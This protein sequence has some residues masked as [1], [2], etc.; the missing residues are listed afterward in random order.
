MPS[1][2]EK[3]LKHYR[4]VAELI[5]AAKPLER[6]QLNTGAKMVLAEIKRHLPDADNETI[7][8]FMAS[9]GYMAAGLAQMNIRE[10]A[11]TL[12][13]VFDHHMLAVCSMLEL[14]NLDDGD[15]AGPSVEEIVEKR[16]AREAE[17]RE[18]ASQASS[19]DMPGQYL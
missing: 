3:E 19:D 6:T 4:G 16:N 18:A 9:I 12:E 8:S 15:E 5:Y 2:S 17:W 11:D 1:A 10:L 7:R 13:M 14:V